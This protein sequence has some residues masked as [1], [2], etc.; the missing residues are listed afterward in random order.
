MKKITTY[1]CTFMKEISRNIDELKCI[2][3]FFPRI[4]TVKS[5]FALLWNI[6]FW[7]V[8]GLLSNKCSFQIKMSEKRK[9]HII[10][11]KFKLFYKYRLPPLMKY[12]FSY[13]FMKINPVFIEQKNLKYSV[14]LKS[15]HMI[16]TVSDVNETLDY[17]IVCSCNLVYKPYFSYVWLNS[18][19]LLVLFERRV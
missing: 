18:F 13:H 7:C 19:F 14:K 16:I 11:R 5:Y 17:A 12:L 1:S 8:A 4:F 10:N 15:C 6:F 2:I 3:S 9:M